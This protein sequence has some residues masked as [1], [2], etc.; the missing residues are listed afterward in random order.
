MTKI[1]PAANPRDTRLAWALFVGALIV[2]LFYIAY[3]DLGNAIPVGTD[4]VSYDVF[5]RAILS[6]T[7]W[8]THPGPELF[9]PPGYPMIL[10]AQYALFGD[11]I[12]AR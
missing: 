5:A 6:G 4:A 11:R 9:R 12:H 10:A 8:L 7:G 3:R 1:N 2:R